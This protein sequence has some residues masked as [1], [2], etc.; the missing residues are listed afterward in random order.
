MFKIGVHQKHKNVT[1]DIDGKCQSFCLENVESEYG[2]RSKLI[3]YFAV[4]AIRNSNFNVEKR[5]HDFC[6]H[7]VHFKR[8][9]VVGTLRERK[10]GRAEE[11]QV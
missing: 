6:R 11:I 2:D 10:A 9:L 1:L 5:F 7:N 3:K 8:K 4:L